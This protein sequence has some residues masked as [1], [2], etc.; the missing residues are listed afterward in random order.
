MR[1][2]GGKTVCLAVCVCVHV[3]PDVNSAQGGAMIS[4]GDEFSLM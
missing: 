2:D 3:L 1:I 4:L